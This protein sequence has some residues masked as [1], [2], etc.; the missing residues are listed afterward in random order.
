MIIS[1]IITRVIITTMFVIVIQKEKADKH[2]RQV[3][4]LKSKGKKPHLFIY[5][6]STSG[7]IHLP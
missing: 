2:N 6:F 4:A 7:L 1:I 5:F 3:S